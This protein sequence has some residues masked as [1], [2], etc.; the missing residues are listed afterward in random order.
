MTKEIYRLLENYMLSCMGDSAHDKEHVYR[1]LYSALEIAREEQNVD[2]DILICACLLHDIGRKEQF[3]NPSLCHAQVGSEKAYR[4][5]TRQGFKE[6]FAARVRHCILTHRYRNDNVPETIEARILFDADKLDATGVMGIAR[7]LFYKG[8]ISEPLYSVD[9]QGRVSDGT[10]DTS[11]SFLQEYKYKLENIYSHFYT[12]KG[13]EMA[14]ARRWA[15]VDFYESL[16][17]EVRPIYE[18]GRQE[19]AKRGLDL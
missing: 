15:A 12:K 6:S 17:Q 4:F 11:P 16:L 18:K 9:D 14:Q 3:E 10:N 13:E 7:T 8:Q 5:L 1:V 19:L 2:Y